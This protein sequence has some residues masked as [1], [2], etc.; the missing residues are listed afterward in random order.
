MPSSAHAPV[1]PTRFVLSGVPRVSFDF[2]AIGRCPEDYTFGGC[3]RAALE[4][5]GE[6]LGCQHLPTHDPSWHLNCSYAFLL[7]VSGMAARLVWKPG[8][9]PDN[10]GSLIM[11]GGPEEPI[12]RALG[13]VGYGYEYLDRDAGGSEAMFRKRIVESLR[14]KGHPVL[15]QGVVGPPE[16]C[17]VTGYDEGGD[18]LIGWSYLQG[19]PEF[20]AE[21]STEPDGQFRKRGW[22]DD[23]TSLVLIG[24]KGERPDRKATFREALR[25]TLH[26]TRTPTSSD[27]RHNGLAAYDAW[28]EHLLRD[29]DWPADDLPT[30]QQ[31]HMVHDDEVL[32]VAEGRWYGSLFLTQI[33]SE[34]PSM[35]ESLLKAAACWAGEHDLMWRVWGLAGGIGRDE[36]NVRALAR[37]DVRRE[38]VQVIHQARDKD[39]EAAGHI[40]RALERA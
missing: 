6:G 16:F 17:L 36:S 23:T 15:A 7:G 33:A 20:D 39:A 9:H 21:P 25:W 12:R 28:A 18:V 24:D 19:M 40:A 11:P 2:G 38:I 8:W 1:S 29:G 22:Y 5:L 26:V 37:P 14:D 30:W 35:A 34:E 13:A 32:A 3:L 4:Y 31:R 10:I 27:G